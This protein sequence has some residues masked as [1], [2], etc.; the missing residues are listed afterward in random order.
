MRK[1]FL[2]SIAIL[3]T[4]TAF[5][6]S[7]SSQLNGTLISLEQKDTVGV[8]GAAI[9]L[10]SLRD[11]LDKKYTILLSEVHTNSRVSLQVSTA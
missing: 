5:A 8:V 4:M 2:L 1:F 3:A 10:T 11:T 9:E 7:K 6:Q